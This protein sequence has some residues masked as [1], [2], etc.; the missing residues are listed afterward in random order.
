MKRFFDAYT[1]LYGVIGSP[2]RH[3]LSPKIH[4]ELFMR[5]SVNAVYVAFE[6]TDLEKVICGVRELGIA[7]LSV[8][9]PHKVEIKKFIDYEDELAAQIGAVN[10]IVNMNGRLKGYNT[11]VTGA[12]KALRE[13]TDIKGKRVLIL[14]AGGVAR[15]IG[16]GIN[17]EGG[18]PVIANRT[19]S[20][21]RA[22][23]MELKCEY[24]SPQAAFETKPE[25]LINAT[26]IGMNPDSNASPVPKE[27][28]RDMIVFDT[29]YNPLETR[30]LA[31]AKSNGCKIVTGLRMFVHQARLQ[32]EL[33]TGIEP[34]ADALEEFLFKEMKQI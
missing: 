9:I 30:L 7:G 26:S 15:A 8:T 19:E 23:A 13:K 33:W 31:D 21:G 6:V 28:V 27:K 16:F 25:I 2:V 1:K 3:S 12:M 14:G 4:N 24:V 18:T 29:V 5:Y 32:F 11:D 22:L 10:T 34:N 17:A 20:K